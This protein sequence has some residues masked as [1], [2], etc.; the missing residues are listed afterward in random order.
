MDIMV[1]YRADTREVVVQ[2]HDP[3]T[4]QKMAAHMCIEDAEGFSEAIAI[5]V[6]KVKEAQKE[7]IDNIQ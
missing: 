3:L 1:Y 5:S 6:Y 2:I 7:E 4:Q